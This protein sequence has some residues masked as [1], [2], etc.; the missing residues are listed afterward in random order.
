MQAR[1]DTGLTMDKVKYVTAR[2]YSKRREEIFFRINCGQLNDLFSEYENDEYESMTDSF[3]G[4]DDRLKIVTHSADDA[5]PVYN[6]PYLILDVREVELYNE[7]HIVHGR[8]FP[9]ALL[10][11]DQL[12]PDVYKFRNK[13]ESLIILYCNDEKTSCDAAKIMVDRGIDNI[14]VLNGGLYDFAEDFPSYIEGAPPVPPSS[15]RSKKSSSSSSSRATT[16]TSEMFGLTNLLNCYMKSFYSKFSACGYILYVCYMFSYSFPSV[17]HHLCRS[18]V[19][20]ANLSGLGKIPED[21]SY[22]PSFPSGRDLQLTPRK[23]SMHNSMLQGA[24]V[25]PRMG[26][27]KSGGSRLDR[28]SDAGASTQSNMSGEGRSPT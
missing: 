2:E 21:S 19:D 27:S 26:G 10:R 7:C 12:H 24:A 1:L 17:S 28:R 9:F 13:P 23:L 22:V 16:S 3:R 6:K 4:G 18:V 15:S 20:V 25:D 11:R 8:S 14:Y 5:E